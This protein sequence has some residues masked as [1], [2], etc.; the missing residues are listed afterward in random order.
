[1]DLQAVE[2]EP[3]HPLIGACEVQFAGSPLGRPKYLLAHPPL[4]IGLAK[5]AHTQT[6]RHRQGR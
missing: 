5:S 3:P 4:V 6:C 1:M 2:L